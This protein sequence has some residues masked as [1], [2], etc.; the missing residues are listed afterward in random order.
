MGRPFFTDQNYVR[1]MNDGLHTKLTRHARKQWAKKF[2]ASISVTSVFAAF[3][4]AL[5]EIMPLE[6]LGLRYIAAEGV[7]SLTVDDGKSDKRNS[8]VRFQGGQMMFETGDLDSVDDI[9]GFVCVQDWL[10]VPVPKGA[11]PRY[12]ALAVWNDCLGIN[13]TAS[14]R[15]NIARSRLSSFSNSVGWV[16]T[17]HTPSNAVA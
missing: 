8:V 1:S 4:W 6:S 17:H 14:L 11:T 10:G 13:S 2:A 9:L 12:Q 7:D 15:A 3:A 16:L 5:F